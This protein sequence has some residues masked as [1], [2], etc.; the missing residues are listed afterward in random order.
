M[1]TFLRLASHTYSIQR[2]ARIYFAI[3]LTHFPSQFSHRFR[4]ISFFRR[5]HSV[6]PHLPIHPPCP[7]PCLPLSISHHPSINLSIHSSIHSAPPLM[8]PFRLT[9]TY[10]VARC[11]EVGDKMGGRGS[12]GKR[13]GREASVEGRKERLRK[14]GEGKTQTAI[15]CISSG[16]GRK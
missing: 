7:T 15:D 2:L 16:T 12:Q 5:T 8:S 4:P 10:I 14:G 13:T 6:S 11:G 9:L 1:Q 3:E